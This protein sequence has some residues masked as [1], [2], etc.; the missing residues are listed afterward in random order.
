[1]L[2]PRIGHFTYCKA[3]IL[4]SIIELRWQHISQLSLVMLHVLLVSTGQIVWQT[5]SSRR[6][7]LYSDLIYTFCLTLL[8]TK[9]LS[10]G[11]EFVSSDLKTTVDQHHLAPRQLHLHQFHTQLIFNFS[12]NKQKFLWYMTKNKNAL[13]KIAHLLVSHH[14]LLLY[15]TALTQHHL[16]AKPL[17]CCFQ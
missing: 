1:M 12:N 7:T 16:V 2:A 9:E 11:N 17:Q 13:C 10:S 8:C 4:S 5:Y 3:C 6:R 15:G 14:Y